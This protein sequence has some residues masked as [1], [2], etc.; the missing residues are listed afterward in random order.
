MVHYLDNQLGGELRPTI[1]LEGL[2]VYLSG[3]HFKPE[4]LMPRAAALL[5]LGWYQPLENLTENFYPS[6]HEI[7]YMEAGALVEYMVER[8]GWQA[9]NRF[10]RDIRPGPQGGGQVG[11]MDAALTRH[12]G[13]T[14][15]QLEADFLKALRLETVTGQVKDD[16]RLTVA[17]F[18]TA[19]RYQQALDPSAYYLTTW[20]PDGKQMR[21]RGIV[22]DFLR[23]P[24]AP[25]NVALET[26]LVSA[27]N[28][29]RAGNYDEA[30]Q[31][32]ESVNQALTR[33]A[34]TP[35]G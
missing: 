35:G 24:S 34:P 10:Y 30:E 31:L 18:D 29:L 2:A 3:G 19:R 21:E 28:Q 7:G 11:P 26:L 12:F 5:E 23:H 14:L 6:Q 20:L 32:I 9:F 8:W 4:P 13:I 33:L 22:A 1:L 25:I 16:V 27:Y 17:F 15:T